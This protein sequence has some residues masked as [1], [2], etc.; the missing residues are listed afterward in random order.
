[1]T[2]RLQEVVRWLTDVL[3]T[4][5]RSTFCQELSCEIQVQF[6]T[7][8][9]RGYHSRVLPWLKDYW[10]KS[11]G[12]RQSKAYLA[13]EDEFDRRVEATDIIISDLS[14]QLNATSMAARAA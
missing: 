5:T 10:C 6:R 11:F 13:A 14:D 8:T 9:S 4:Y 2:P 12:R 7:L 1:M 3:D